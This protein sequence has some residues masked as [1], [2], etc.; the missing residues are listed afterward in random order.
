MTLQ[1]VKGTAPVS[2]IE[3]LLSDHMI[4]KGITI[5]DALVRT[6]QYTADVKL[7]MSGTIMAKVTATGLYGPVK[8]TTLAATSALGATTS[9]LT[10][11]AFF[12]VNDSVVIGSE[13][14]TLTA[15]DYDT[16][17]VTHTALAGQQLAGVTVKE[18]NGLET[19][20]GILFNTTDVTDGDTAAAIL[21]Q[22]VVKEVRLI[23]S[24]ALTKADLTKV[25]YR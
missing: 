5:D 15:I 10:N 25:E 13:T 6:G 4:R 20:D 7:L 24:N 21:T 19:A 18:D 14:K 3:F 22:A 11:A 2:D 8:K 9:T 16:N 12:Q 17:V 1:R 23:G